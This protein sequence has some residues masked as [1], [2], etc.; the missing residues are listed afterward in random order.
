MKRAASPAMAAT[1]PGASPASWAEPNRSP[2]PGANR[3]SGTVTF[4]ALSAA[5]NF[6]VAEARAGVGGTDGRGAAGA[7]VQPARPKAASS[8]TTDNDVRRIFE[9]RRR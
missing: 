7:D 9:L 3:T 6:A 4:G 1:G 5:G 2:C 8:A